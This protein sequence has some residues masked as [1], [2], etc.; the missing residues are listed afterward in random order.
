MKRKSFIVL[1]LL[2]LF[3]SQLIIGK[4][5]AATTLRD[6]SSSHWAYGAVKEVVEDYQIMQGYPPGYFKG[7]NTMTRYEF[8][9]AISNLIGVYNKEFLADREDL[10]SLV[11]IMEQFQEE[12]KM[13][14]EKV[15]N[16]NEKIS[17]LDNS[18]S[19]IKQNIANINLEELSNRL[20]GAEDRI[21][22]L[23]N[24]GLVVDT[25][26][27]GTIRDV[28]K[29]GDSIGK[30]SSKIRTALKTDQEQTQVEQDLIQIQME[31]EPVQTLFVRPE[32]DHQVLMEI[33]DN[34]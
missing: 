34:L 14:T 1:S 29:V 28:K 12:L 11:H 17:G 19:V 5:S 13:L 18:I 6:V 23:Q 20:A 27:K 10:S 15:S 3:N 7:A 8:A 2:F 4:V 9:V 31:G 22:E 21:T 26:I 33:E 32:Q 30:L 16:M 24:S 25:L